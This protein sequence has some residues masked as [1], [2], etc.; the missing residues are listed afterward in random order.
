MLKVANGDTETCIRS[1]LPDHQTSWAKPTLT[2]G[3][4]RHWKVCA[5]RQH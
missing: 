5:L 4:G 1:L 2:G 3:L